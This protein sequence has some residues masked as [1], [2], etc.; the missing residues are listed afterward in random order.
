MKTERTEHKEIWRLSFVWKG[1]W[2]V[3]LYSQQRNNY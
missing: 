1:G 3:Y 2:T